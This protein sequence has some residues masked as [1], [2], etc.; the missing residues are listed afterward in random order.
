MAKFDKEGIYEE[1]LCA[2][3][4][5]FDILISLINDATSR[6]ELFNQIS[7]L[8]LTPVTNVN[9][10]SNLPLV[11]SDH[12]SSSTNNIKQ[13]AKSEEK[14]LYGNKGSSIEESSKTKEEI[15]ANEEN[16][17]RN[18]TLNQSPDKEYLKINE[19]IL[20]PSQEIYGISGRQ[21]I[22]E[23][24]IDDR[25]APKQSHD[26]IKQ[27]ENGPFRIPEAKLR[28]G[29]DRNKVSILLEVIEENIIKNKRKHREKSQSSYKCIEYTLDKYHKLK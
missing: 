20:N 1:L 13:S 12:K 16:Y 22:L 27:P 29:V 2:G 23:R 3:Y 18:S 6:E 19:K 4:D 24:K 15:K 11:S 5:Q 21:Q 25:D 26:K 7:Q 14:L 10:T 8:G 28:Q 9:P 17:P